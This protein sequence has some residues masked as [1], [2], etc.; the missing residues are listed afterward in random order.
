MKTIK[1]TKTIV[2]GLFTLC[3]MG[4]IN[5]TFAGIKPTDPAE[6]KFI[7]KVDEH[8]VFQLTL[9]NQENEVYYVNIK[10]ENHNVFYSEKISGVNLLRRYQLAVDDADLNA[11]GFGVSVEVTSAKTHKTQVYKIS[12]QTK[13][14]KNIIVAQL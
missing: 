4:L 5:T 7:G 14:I 1:S 8:P 6:L 10:D 12:T 3:T 2:M 13:V 11:P 9:N